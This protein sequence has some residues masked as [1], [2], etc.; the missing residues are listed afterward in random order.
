MRYI[1]GYSS[2]HIKHTK[3]AGVSSSRMFMGVMWAFTCP[4]VSRGCLESE[5]LVGVT[6]LEIMSLDGKNWTLR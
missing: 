4:R 1:L 3:V 6:A 2:Q 5:K